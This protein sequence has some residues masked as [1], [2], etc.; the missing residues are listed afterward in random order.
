M[1]QWRRAAA[2]LAVAMVWGA[3][4]GWG[5]VDLLERLEQRGVLTAA[6]RQELVAQQP[7]AGPAVADR[8]SFASRDGR[9]SGRLYGYGQVRYTFEDRKQADDLSR[10]SVQRVRLGLAGH[11][12]GNNLTYKVY[13]NVYSGNE[14]S[15]DLFDFYA[16]YAFA[17]SLAVRAGAYKVPYGIQWNVSA[18]RLQ[19]VERTGVDA[20]FRFDR[21]T[22][23]TVHGTLGAG[24]AYDAGVFNG[25]GRNRNNVD[26]GHLYVGRLLWAPF[27]GRVFAGQ[28]SLTRPSRPQLFLSASAA[29]DDDVSSHTRS[30][31]DG[32]LEA[33]GTSDVASV[34]AF[35]GL[36]YRGFS[37][38]AEGHRRRIDPLDEGAANETAVGYYV[39]GGALVWRDMVEVAGRYE[40]FDPDDDRGDDRTRAYGVALNLFFAG[41]R[42]KLQTDLFHTATEAG[43]GST[44]TEDRVRVQYQIAF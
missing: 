37:L 39:Q 28:S 6:E 20:N 30:N 42:S 36:R 2:A 10:F 5:A 18:S 43:P 27:G 12:L 8:L 31:L 17:P 26:D 15:T 40:T 44:D 29:Y 34:A 35:V 21:D 1:A 16:D 14:T 11:A 38:G 7:P 32:R 19:F 25:E 9:F 4:P 3:A 33:L 23:I 22:G 13:L 41:H 24:L